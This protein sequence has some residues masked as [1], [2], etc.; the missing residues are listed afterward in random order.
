[1]LHIIL[2]KI[3]MK[4]VDGKEV[5]SIDI[6]LMKKKITWEMEH[7]KRIDTCISIYRTSI[8]KVNE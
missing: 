4:E 2:T 3:M 7:N 1:M 5:L 6:T 8:N